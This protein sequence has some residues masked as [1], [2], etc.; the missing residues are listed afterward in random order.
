MKNRFGKS[1]AAVALVSLAVTGCSTAKSDSSTGGTSRTLVLTAG[2]GTSFPQNFNV[3]APT[4]AGPWGPGYAFIYEP[5]LVVD[6]TQPNHYKPWLATSWDYSNGGKD[7]NW[8]IRKGVKWSDGQ[9]L[10]AADV[11]YSLD[12]WAKSFGASWKNVTVKG[13]V[14]TVHYDNASYT[15]IQSYIYPVVVPKHI[16]GKHNAQTW[17]NPDPVGTG[18][19]V[20]SKFTPQAMF[21]KVRSD[22]WGGQSKGVK[23]FE[24]VTSAQPD[25]LVANLNAG[26]I[27]WG[28][29]TLPQDG[30]QFTSTDQTHHHYNVYSTG[31]SEGFD[32][33]TT[34]MPFSDVHVR[35]AFVNG[36]DLP[37]VQKAANTGL[38]VP[39]VTGLDPQVWGS[40]IPSPYNTPQ[41]QDIDAAKKAL[42]DGGWTV[43]GGNL[44][45]AGKSYP[46]VITVPNT[47][48]QAVTEAQLL[49]QQ[50]KD[51]L[52]IAVKVNQVG[53]NVNSDVE[54]K[55]KFDLAFTGTTY[56]YWN[57]AG[58]Y[59]PYGASQNV[60]PN[61]PAG[62]NIGRWY[63][64][65]FQ[66]LLTKYA[67]TDPSDSASVDAIGKKI[68][69]LAAQDAPFLATHAQVVPTDINDT[70][71]TNWPVE[72]KAGFAPSSTS[73][74]DAIETLMSLT[75]T[76]K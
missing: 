27:D 66:G 71:W 50:W 20:L 68:I 63:D 76:G 29:T 75:P 62:N 44:T 34:R 11:A 1:L 12:Q 25:A 60:K 67:A 5:L 54:S 3:F 36:A 65:K 18:P 2:G 6:R 14:V 23:K 52:G 42:S 15:S 47:N 35:Q 33:N 39:S 31:S 46:V 69:T 64:T 53:D 74:G 43:K 13:D 56:N 32:F 41:A 40:V 7:L 73:P 55:A 37:S 9:P 38:P 51:A 19:A 21:F 26:K 72:G 61:Q 24:V 59:A 10:T 58:A 30:K 70:H 4:G 8:T 45:K 22:Y 16:W 57:V 17:R 28:N 49:A 48:A